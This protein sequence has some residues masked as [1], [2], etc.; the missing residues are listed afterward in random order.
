MIQLKYTLFFFPHKRKEE[1]LHAHLVCRVKWNGSRSIVSLNLGFLVDPEKWDTSTQMCKLRSTHGPMKVPAQVINNEINRYRDTAAALFADF[2]KL[3]K[4][5]SISEVRSGLRVRLGLDAP[6]IHT[7]AEAFTQFVAEESVR[8]AWSEA[9]LRKMQT[10]KRHMGDFAPF[11]TF[12]GFTTYNFA[13]YVEFLRT[14]EGHNDTTIQRQLGYVRWFCAWADRKGLMPSNDYD[15]FRP[16]LKSPGKPVIFLDWDE[17]MKFWAYEA[18]EGHQYLNDV[19]DVFLFCCFTSLRYSDAQNLRWTDVTD[20]YIRVVTQKTAHAL[21]ID[22]NKWSREILERH[23]DRDHGDGH[24]LPQ[25]PNQVMNRYLK[26]IS[27]D[28]GLNSKMTVVEY[29]GS[30][31]SEVTCEKWGLMGTHAGRR[32]FICN[33]LKMGIPPTVVMQWTGH[34]DYRAMRPYIDVTDSQRKKAMAGFDALSRDTK[35]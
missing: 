29:H 32:T 18:P 16:K 1:D 28:C 2:A 6:G 20:D 21:T 31:R 13:K 11:Q 22:L 30:Q 17:L 15:V 24:C 12:D 3:D 23:I 25:I 8:R 34:N 26:R 35:D 33:A 9:T 7:T 5:P 4:W 19:R 27:K 10:V 14:S